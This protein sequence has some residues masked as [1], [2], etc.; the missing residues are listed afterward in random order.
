M[1][2][3]SGAKVDRALGRI[4]PIVPI[5]RPGRPGE[6]RLGFRMRSLAGADQIARDIFLHGW[7]AFERPLPDVF[8]ALVA[9]ES[10]GLVLDVGANTGFYSLLAVR[11]SRGIFVHAFEPFPTAEAHL[12]KNLRINRGS[13][14]IRVFNQA[15]CDQTGT[16]RLYV[17]L[18]DHGLVETSC[19]LNGGFKDEFSAVLDVRSLTLDTHL[20]AVSHPSVR[21]LKIDVESMEHKVL[22]GARALLATDR[23]TVFVEVLPF[24]SLEELEDIRAAYDYL[25]VRLRPHTAIVSARVLYDEKAWNHLFLP[26]E[27]LHSVL[28]LL[29]EVGLSVEYEDQRCHAENQRWPAGGGD[30]P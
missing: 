7:Y 13:R 16:A 23:P 25:S 18:P 2:T 15:I 24:G 14:R 6:S 4:P 17:P 1:A 5:D 27:Q 28:A 26:R 8:A 10:R 21:M 11:A 3:R 12:R 20:E 19:S 22:A 9:R 29:S 30:R